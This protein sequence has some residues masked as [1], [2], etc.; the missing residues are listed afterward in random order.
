[1]NLWLT[2][3]RE[4]KIYASRAQL[5]DDRPSNRIFG[6]Q[7]FSARKPVCVLDKSGSSIA[8]YP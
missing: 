6:G 3:I 2:D 5:F 1:M 7:V 8:N 4:A